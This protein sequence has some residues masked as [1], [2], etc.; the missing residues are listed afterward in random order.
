MEYET[1]VE[2]GGT[3]SLRSL[4]ELRP[5]S[6]ILDVGCGAGQ[7]L[8]ALAPSS[9]LGI[10]LEFDSTCLEIFAALRDV[11]RLKNVVA[12]R[13]DAEHL[14]FRDGVFDCVVCRVVLMY[15]RVPLVIQE[16][17]RVSADKALVYLHL[18]D[19]WFYL[20][21]FLTLQWERGGVPFALINGLLLQ[22]L[23]VQIPVRTGRTLTIRH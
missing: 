10:G 6:R 5:E 23:G 15:V 18:T 9:S 13:A 16:I 7:T 21:K 8:A 20:R 19:V 22:T 4:L 2:A 3:Y 1:Q 12:V 11:E 14:P 17:A